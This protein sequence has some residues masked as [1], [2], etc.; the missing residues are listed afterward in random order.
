ME[1]Q[2]Q[3]ASYRS[4][5]QKAILAMLQN[6]ILDTGMEQTNPVQA[7]SLSQ[8]NTMTSPTKDDNISVITDINDEDDRSID[9]SH[10]EHSST[11]HPSKTSLSIIIGDDNAVEG[12]ASDVEKAARIL[13]ERNYGI[14]SLLGLFENFYALQDIS[15]SEARHM[16]LR[17]IVG[18]VGI[19]NNANMPRSPSRSRSRQAKRGQVVVKHVEK[20]CISLLTSVAKTFQEELSKILPVIELNQIVEEV[21]K[22]EE[23]ENESREM[24]IDPSGKHHYLKRIVPIHRVYTTPQI[25]EFLSVDDD[26]SKYEGAA[27]DFMRAVDER[28]HRRGSLTSAMSGG[29]SP[30][31]PPP[32]DAGKEDASQTSGSV[33][34]D[35]LGSLLR[36]FT[37]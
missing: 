10:T 13:G 11:T 31:K 12:S 22:V 2:K 36:G 19:Q 32:K 23:E 14:K 33:S 5:I 6:D 9:D 35:S 16:A 27:F 26:Y 4:D 28:D 21:M 17:A 24:Y 20:I 29:F 8:G 37:K 15:F 34:H 18:Y 7:S 1:P 3:V 30:F 25:N